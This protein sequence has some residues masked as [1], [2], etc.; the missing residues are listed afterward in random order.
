MGALQA[1]LEADTN[2]GGQDAWNI[3]TPAASTV[4]RIADG[5]ALWITQYSGMV[6]LSCKLEAAAGEG[7]RGPSWARA[8]LATALISSRS[9]TCMWQSPA[10]HTDIVRTGVGV[11]QTVNVCTCVRV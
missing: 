2:A 9:M 3:G 4:A 8:F 6:T 1:T 10:G 5:S 7:A 11:R